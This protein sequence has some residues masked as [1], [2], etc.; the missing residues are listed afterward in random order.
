M[1]KASEQE[2]IRRVYTDPDS[3]VAYSSVNN[4]LGAVRKVF[5]KMTRAKVE[6]VLQRITAYTIHRPRRVRFKRLRTVPAGFM[7]DVQV[8]LA[9]FQ[10]VAEHNDNFKYLLVG[11]DVLS[12]RVFTAPVKSKHSH[13]MIAAF[14]LLFRQMPMLPRRIFSDK[15]KEFVA[16]DVRKFL[17]DHEIDK[18]TAESPDVK[19]AVAERFIRTIKGRLWK[20]DPCFITTSFR[21]FSLHKTQRWLE[22]VPK[23]VDGL[24]KTVSQATG[25]RPC[26]IDFSNEDKVLEDVYGSL[27]KDVDKKSR[28]Q[29]FRV[30]DKVRIASYKNPF[31]KSYLPNYTREVFEI[32][33]VADTDPVTY[34]LKDEK[35][36]EITG[37]FYAH[38]FSRS[39]KPRDKELVIAK[40]YRTRMRKG[41][42]REFLVSFKNRPEYEKTWVTM[43]D[44]I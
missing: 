18:L 9:D 12:R 2:V 25:L 39:K 32:A 34:E 6:D 38:E 28:P 23:I 31:E 41:G 10:D 44:I 7:S 15:G 40:F 30:G 35:G 4:V 3:P 1:E 43:T 33:R 21:H 20:Y 19:A 17:D 16:Y 11:V 29:D 37:K 42:L 8:D 13:N 22:A 36:E 26:D 5:P 27:K 14:K 24:N